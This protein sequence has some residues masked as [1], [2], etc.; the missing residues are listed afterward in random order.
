MCLAVPAKII[1][2]KDD[3]LGP[4]AVVDYQGG[5]VEVS[6]QVVPDA[7]VGD[8]VLIHAGFA[9]ERLDADEARELWEYLEEAE[10]TDEMPEDLKKSEDRT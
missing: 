4:L 3:P 9:L 2:M 6:L 5:R 1:E 7:K 8:W 10:I